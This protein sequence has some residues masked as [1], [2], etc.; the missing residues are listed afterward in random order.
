MKIN[1]YFQADIANYTLLLAEWRIK[2]FREFPYLYEGTIAYEQEYLAGYVRGKDVMLL[3]V[4]ENNETVA[5]ATS[6]AILGEADILAHANEHLKDKVDLEKCAYL[7]G[8]D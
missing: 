6:I 5:I 4:T 1:Q 8:C 2:Y 3:T 7:G